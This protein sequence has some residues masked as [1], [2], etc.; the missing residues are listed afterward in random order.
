MDTASLH[1]IERVAEDW[2]CQ[3]LRMGWS[4]VLFFVFEM[5]IGQKL[6][7]VLPILA[8]GLGV[9]SL[10]S[11]MYAIRT[12]KLKARLAIIQEALESRV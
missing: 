2:P 7:Q 5:T 12:W 10:V 8:L 4:L 1:P 11:A 6:P 9:A 3:R